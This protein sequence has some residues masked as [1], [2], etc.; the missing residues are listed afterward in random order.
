VLSDRLFKSLST[1][2][3]R[4]WLRRLAAIAFPFRRGL[5]LEIAR[6]SP[7]IEVSDVD[8]NYLTSQVL[9]QSGPDRYTVPV[10]L[11]PLL[12]SA[13]QRPSEKDVL[14]ASGR[15]VFRNAGTSKQ[16][17]FWDFHG[18]ILALVIATD[19]SRRTR[20]RP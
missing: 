6:M 3:H 16:I 11:R 13:T 18:A 2:L 15:Y 7:T 12:K 9:D 14:A 1:D 17:N 5:A 10:L 20:S 19:G 8:W 4:T